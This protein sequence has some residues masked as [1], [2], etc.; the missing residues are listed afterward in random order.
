VASTRLDGGG[1]GKLPSHSGMF[2]KLVRSSSQ[3]QQELPVLGNTASLLVNAIEENR[4]Y[5]QIG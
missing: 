4:I 5:G 1:S 3:A 2:W